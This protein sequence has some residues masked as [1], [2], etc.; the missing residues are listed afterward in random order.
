MSKK[1]EIEKLF[2]QGNSFRVIVTE[3]NLAT[4][5]E[6]I[7]RRAVIFQ[8]KNMFSSLRTI[9]HSFKSENRTLKAVCGQSFQASRL[10]IFCMYSGFV[11]VLYL[12]K[13]T[14]AD[15]QEFTPSLPG[16]WHFIFIIKLKYSYLYKEPEYEILCYQVRHESNPVR[17]SFILAAI[18]FICIEW[19]GN[20]SFIRPQK[21]FLFKH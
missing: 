1:M 4:I 18:T 20:N 12:D 7:E 11:Q 3:N 8:N 15:V 19:Q 10:I 9:Q 2:G 13:L 5:T 17:L 16:M 14:L 6:V 21:I